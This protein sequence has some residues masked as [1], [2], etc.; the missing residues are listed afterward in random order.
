MKLTCGATREGAGGAGAGGSGEGGGAIAT[1]G[2]GGGGTVCTV[3]VGA[4]GGFWICTSGGGMNAGGGGGSLGGG[5]KFSGGGGGGGF[6]AF[7]GGSIAAEVKG[8]SNGITGASSLSEFPVNGATRGAAGATT[9]VITAIPFCSTTSDLTITKTNNT[10]TIVP[11]APITYTIAARNNGLKD[12]FGVEVKDTLPAVFGNIS[13]TCSPTSGSSCYVANGSGHVDTKV[14]LLSGGVATFQVTATPIPTATGMVTNTATIAAPPGAVDTNPGN[15]SATDTDTLT[16]QSDLSITKSNGTTS[17]TP[18]TNTTYTIVVTNN[19]PSTVPNA[20]VSDP[21]P[22]KLSNATWT[23]TASQGSACGAPNGQGGIATTVSLIPGGRATFTLSASVLP[24]A[25]G[26]LE[27]VVTVAP[28]NGVAD[29]TP[30]NNT[31][32]DTDAL[33]AQANLSIIKTASPNPVPASENVT[34]TIVVTN[35]GPSMADAVSVTDPLAAGLTLVSASS[36]RG[37]CSGT[38]TVT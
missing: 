15:N 9:S 28:P 3:M 22:A 1:G 12:V 23:C 5:G 4:G 11:G 7:S 30:G 33:S 8:G 25:T 24:D 27:N 32:R 35:S 31:A 10:N 6:I 18:G 19:G 2:A 38:Q 14:N 17:V 37:T 26:T 13:W 16:P 20:T 21:L 34:F 29:L 36:T